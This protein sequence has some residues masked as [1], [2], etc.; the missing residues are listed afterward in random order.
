MEESSSDLCLVTNGYLLY[1]SAVTKSSIQHGIT[2]GIAIRSDMSNNPPDS[3]LWNP[4]VL[5]VADAKKIVWQ[6][7]DIY[8]GS[9]TCSPINQTGS[10]STLVSWRH[11][12][13]VKDCGAFPTPPHARSTPPGIVRKGER[14]QVKCDDGYRPVNVSSNSTTSPLCL[15]SGTFEDSITC[16]PVSCGRYPPPPNASVFPADDVTFGGGVTI[17]CEKGYILSDGGNAAPTCQADGSFTQGKTCEQEREG[18]CGAYPGLLNGQVMPPGSLPVWGSINLTC[19]DGYRLVV[20]YRGGEDRASP[21]CVSSLGRMEIDTVFDNSYDRSGYVTGTPISRPRADFSHIL[22]ARCDPVSCGSLLP[23][24]YGFVEPVG[25][26]LFPGIVRIRCDEGYV[27]SEEGSASPRCLANGT[28]ELGKTCISG[29]LTTI[30]IGMSSGEI[31]N[32]SRTLVSERGAMHMS[33]LRLWPW[34]VRST[35]GSW[36]EVRK[37]NGMVGFIAW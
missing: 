23:P 22:D 3:V 15:P 12:S 16:V 11:N 18:T 6:D 21:R 13:P 7:Q 26:I 30:V 5:S 9:M 31:A 33:S 4:I 36:T 2:L 34:Q 14:V 17:V 35:Y 27:L 28:F 32:L 25:E 1:V 19:N 8:P 29:G 24:R 37:C 20:N 10:L